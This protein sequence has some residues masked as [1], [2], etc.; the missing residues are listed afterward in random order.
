MKFFRLGIIILTIWGV[1]SSCEKAKD[2]EFVRVAGINF[3]N[4]GFSKSIVRLTL[5]YYN[6]NNFKLKLKDASF[7]LFMD[8][9]LVGH[10]LQDTMIAIPAKDTFYF[11]VKLE[12]NMENVFKNAL[13]ALMNK[14]VT[15]K[16]TGNCKV[17]KG[18]VYLPFPIK[19]ETKQPIKFF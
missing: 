5:A 10:S 8:D 4:L 14:E 6:P 16:A 9:N 2:L 17:G 12:V 1:A 15:I 7:D 3:D 18:G 19:C 13:G 11:P